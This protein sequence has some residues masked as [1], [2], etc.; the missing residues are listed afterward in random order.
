LLP[1]H[2]RELEDEGQEADQGEEDRVESVQH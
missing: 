1:S 2:P